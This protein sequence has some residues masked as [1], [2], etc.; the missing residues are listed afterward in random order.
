M[1]FHTFM[2]SLVKRKLSEDAIFA[3]PT[4]RFG[5]FTLSQV[6]LRGHFCDTSNAFSSF[7][8]PKG[9]LSP[10]A[11]G[12]PLGPAGEVGGG[13][14]LLEYTKVPLSLRPYGPPLRGP[15]SVATRGR[16]AKLEGKSAAR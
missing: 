4:V 16:P 6:R 1:R 15:I 11:V 3:T 5:T 2:L 13:K 10:G 12:A 14:P 9:A 7:L 8:L